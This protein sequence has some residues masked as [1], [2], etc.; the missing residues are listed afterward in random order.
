MMTPAQVV[1]TSLTTKDDSLPQD[2]SDP[3]GQTTLLHVTPTFKPFTVQNFS[4]QYPYNI[5]QTSDEN[6]EKDNLGD[7]WF[8]QYQILGTNI[9][10]IEQQTVTRITDK[11]L[12]AKG[13]N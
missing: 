4:S 5:K 10:K 12:R 9:I 3:K 1:Q 11:I 13:L 8:I 6:K 7:Y 2:Y